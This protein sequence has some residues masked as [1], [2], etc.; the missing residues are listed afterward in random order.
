MFIG[1]LAP[2]NRRNR[3]ALLFS[4]HEGLQ[5]EQHSS[6]ARQQLPPAGAGE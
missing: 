4:D 1:L 6:L 3:F 2:G 5:V